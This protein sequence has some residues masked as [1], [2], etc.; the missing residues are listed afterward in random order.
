MNKVIL[1]IIILNYN[2][3]HITLD[4]IRSIEK[5]YPEETK[6]GEYELI[7]ADNASPDDSLS[8]FKVYQKHTKIKSFVLCDNKQNLGFSKGNNAA[9]K[10]SNGQY[11]LI[12]NPDTLVPPK[13]LP[14]MINFLQTHPDAGAA[15]C[16][17]LTPGGNLDQNCLRGFP[18]PWN[19]FCHFSGLGKHFPH[20]PFFNGYLQ[21]RWRDIN[22]T[23]EVEAIEGAFMIIPR[24]VGDQ[25]HWFD[26][27][28]FFYGEDL[29]MCYDV[30]KAGYKI[31]YVPDVTIT[32]YGGVSSGIKKESEKITT[33][34][35]ESKKKI[36]HHR[37]NA[38]KIFYQKNYANKY[39]K[40]LT[41]L[42]YKGINSLSKKNT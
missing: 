37:F 22:K 31:Y 30:H 25:I 33:A 8:A 18:T 11:I 41:W 26:E 24:K 6:S 32:H 13:T 27:D 12:L 39:P 35:K 20:I 42:T 4:A 9:I 21:S 10:L 14:V 1:S 19:S 3:K 7:L 5:N 17:I 16:K 2:T 34:N 29:Q 23:Q 15:T 28:Y 38:M 36:Q 40:I